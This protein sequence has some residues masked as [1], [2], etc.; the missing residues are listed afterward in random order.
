MPSGAVPWAEDWLASLNGKTFERHVTTTVLPMSP[1]AARSAA[2]GK[3][4]YGRELTAMDQ[5]I[6]VMLVIVLIGLAADKIMVSPWERF[7]HQLG[8][9][10]KQR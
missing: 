1:R 9:G 10:L 8:T 6:G 7:L 2:A 5:V 4:Q 3:S